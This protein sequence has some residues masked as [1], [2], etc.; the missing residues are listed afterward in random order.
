VPCNKFTVQ[1]GIH[2]KSIMLIFEIGNIKTE[3]G[4]RNWHLTSVWCWG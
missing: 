4:A 3:S 2:Q 1:N